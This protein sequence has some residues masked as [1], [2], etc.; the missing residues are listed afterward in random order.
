MEDERIAEDIQDSD[1]IRAR[2]IQD[3]LVKMDLEFERLEG[4]TPDESALAAAGGP[5]P[6]AFA[7]AF[8]IPPGAV[9]L[10]ENVNTGSKRALT[11]ARAGTRTQP[12]SEPKPPGPGG[13]SGAQS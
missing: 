2:R 3:V 12:D 4:E 9:E 6:P 7:Q 1:I 5:F 13:I 11:S 8:G 10:Q